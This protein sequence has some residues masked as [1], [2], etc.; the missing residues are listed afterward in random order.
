MAIGFHSSSSYKLL[1]P[2]RNV[3]ATPN[4][5]GVFRPIS[6]EYASRFKP[7]RFANFSCHV[8]GPPSPSCRHRPEAQVFPL[9]LR[10]LADT[11][12]EHKESVTMP[13]R[14][15]CDCSLCDN[16]TPF[17]GKPEGVAVVAAP[18]LAGVSQSGPFGEICSQ[19]R[20]SR[21]QSIIIVRPI[22]NL[23]VVYAHDGCSV[24]RDRN[25]S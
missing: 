21:G 16:G 9:P 12:A 5:S 6:L 22:G 24:Q 3:P 19:C 1:T 18:A 11:A 25:L 7:V 10:R 13:P 4:S 17:T 2:S 15:S 20:A 14:R 23:A 8:L